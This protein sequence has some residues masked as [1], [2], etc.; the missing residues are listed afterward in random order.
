MIPIKLT[1]KNFMSYGEEPVVVP[2]EGLHV[3]C[4]SGDNGNGKS[5]LLDAMTWALWNKTRASSMD[6]VIRV[7]ADEVEV[8]FEFELNAQR[9]RI[10]KK[11]RRG[12]AAG[13]EWQLTQVDSQG[14]HTPV[15]GGGQRE[16]G[17]QIVTLLSMEY[18]TFLNSAYLQQ[19]H[20]DEFTRQTPDK[21]KQ[22]LGEILGLERYA[23]LEEKARERQKARKEAVEEFEMQIRLLDSEIGNLPAYEEQLEQTRA[24]L[25]DVTAHVEKQEA[26]TLELRERRAKLNAIAGQMDEAQ[27]VVARIQDDL[28]LR[29]AERCNQ[30]ALL[31]RLQKT[32][33]QKDAIQGDYTL[34]Q[35][36]KARREVLEPEIDAFNKANT[37]LRIV[38]GTIDVAE[39]E[40]RGEIRLY[41]NKVQTADERQREHAK[42][43]SQ[44]KTL[45]SELSGMA[46]VETELAQALEAQQIAQQEFADLGARNKELAT[47]LTELEEVIELLARPHAACPVCESDLSGKK[48]D[49]VMAR[50]QEKR[51]NLV[52]E[53]KRVK[54][55]GAAKKQ[56]VTQSGERVT[57]LTKQRDD[58]TIRANRLHDLTARLET[59][60]NAN[61]DL[62][63][64]SKKLRGLQVQLEKGEFANPQRLRRQQL[65]RDME[66][67]KL[68]KAEHEVVRQQIARLEP[69]HKRYQELEH[70]ESDLPQAM[71]EKAR[72]E[73]VLAAKNK[74]RTEAEARRNALQEQ[75]G[76][77]EEVKRLANVADADLARLQS[78]LNGL[79][80]A[81]GSYVKFIAD[82][83]KASAEKKEREKARAKADDER[84]LY[85]ALM[86]AFG[87]KGVQALIIENAIPELQEETNS[88]L[89]RITDNAMQVMFR[90]T[91]ITRTTKEEVETLD[92]EVMDDVGTRPYEMFSGGE[93]FRVNFAIRIA[94]SRLLARRSGA[95]LQT[96]ILD[97]GFGSQDGKG[98][99]KLIEAIDGIKDD[100]EKI[101]VIT[102]VDELKDAFTHRIE[103]TKDANG[104]H[105][106][107]L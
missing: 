13:S 86:T 51:T 1:L 48:H 10:V 74:E 4:L 37:E 90:T 68:A 55:E 31:E 9:Y 101:F 5:A 17:K 83:A 42:V 35:N 45:K 26:V 107:L 71:E 54:Q 59:Y 30:L 11:R 96:L 19:G 16:V 67:L 52:A 95:K 38:Q 50:Q 21:R 81:E 94:L 75:L 41:E 99:E 66:R 28:K 102:H 7:G 103:V 15:G 34:L 57:A 3:A 92:I 20:A 78:D 40:L 60:A 23:R 72:V 79:K 32:I 100:F 36:A 85:N 6:D 77:Y 46:D 25:D 105:V 12:K 106:H 39:K 61:V 2:F 47:A 58:R 64:A 18:E 63:A 98:R 29:E 56:A 65:E 43:E 84:K 93:A 104:S 33:A 91:K 80:V 88:L 89:A 97:E 24:R 44:I 82:C 76:Q 22:I 69:T 49:I 70:A 8:R 87:R 62:D 73:R 53:Q 27:R 14:N